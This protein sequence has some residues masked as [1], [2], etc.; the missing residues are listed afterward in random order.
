ML[1]LNPGDPRPMPAAAFSVSK[2]R[3]Q[4]MKS[5]FLALAFL[6]ATPAFSQIQSATLKADGLTCSMC[7]K[8]IYKA[9]LKV[10]FVQ[11]VT[12]D[13]EGSVCPFRPTASPKR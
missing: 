1:F 13:I 11:S 10:P 3:I 8:A 6:S 2:K 9:L 12:P 5:L 4:S 7:S